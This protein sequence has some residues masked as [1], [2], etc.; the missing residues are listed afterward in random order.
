MHCL[1]T[2][3]GGFMKFLKIF[4]KMVPALADWLEPR[5]DSRRLRY[6]LGVVAALGV[7]IT[8]V[9]GLW[10]TPADQIQDE[11]VRLIYVHPALAWSSYEAFGLCALASALYLIPA[12][13][14]R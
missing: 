10:V 6:V 7:G 9:L 12:T 14:H 11:F 1:R 5:L 4:L 2:S 8:V 13:K 3:L